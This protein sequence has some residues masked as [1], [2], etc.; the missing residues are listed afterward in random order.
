MTIKEKGGTGG[1]LY[2]L[3]RQT[4]HTRDQ[5]TCRSQH[6]TFVRVTRADVGQGG[7][8]YPLVP[9]YGLTADGAR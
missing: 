5:G 7:T 4:A 6:K 8:P 3:T 2:P 9:P 1:T